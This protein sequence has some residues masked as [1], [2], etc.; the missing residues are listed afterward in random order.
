MLKKNTIYEMH[1]NTF[2]IQY[3]ASKTF[4]KPRNRNKINI[5]KYF[6]FAII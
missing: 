5:E 6:G 1:T 4:I 3:N 2:K